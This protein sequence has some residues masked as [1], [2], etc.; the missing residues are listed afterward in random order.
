MRI[1]STIKNRKKGFTLVEL[2]VVIAVLAILAA[3]AIPVVA[4][5]LNNSKVSVAA[6]NAKLVEQAFKEANAEI[7]VEKSTIYTASSDISDVFNKNG[8]T[9]IESSVTLNSIT[10]DLMWSKSKEQCDYVNTSNAVDIT[11][12][13]ITAA[14]WTIKISP[15]DKTKISSLF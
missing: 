1:Q 3:I 5:T 11:G 8:I 15:T 12:K 13:A 10:Y 6:S 14:D 4:Y 7:A 2:V 9:D